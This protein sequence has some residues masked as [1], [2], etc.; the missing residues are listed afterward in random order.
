LGLLF[1][2]EP[3]LLAKGWKVKVRDCTQVTPAFGY[4]DLKDLSL[5]TSGSSSP[6]KLVRV[7]PLLRLG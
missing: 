6:E 3:Q 4:R 5:P 1:W 7:F 2:P